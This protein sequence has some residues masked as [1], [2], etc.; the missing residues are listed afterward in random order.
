MKKYFF[1]IFSVLSLQIM[2]QSRNADKN[3]FELRMYEYRDDR[4]QAAI[5]EY[6][7]KALI[8]FLH[9]R[10]IGKIGAFTWMGN[11]TAKVKRLYVLIPTRTMAMIANFNKA[12]I[13]DPKVTASA[14]AYV[15]AT[16]EAPAYD[17]IVTYYIEGF[18]LA[19]NL[20]VPALKSSWEERVYELRSYEG[21]S[22]KKYLKKVEMFN[23][24]GE[25]DIFKRLNFN[26]VFYGEVLSG[27]TMP[28]L[29]YMTS[30]EN[31]KD[32]DAHWQAFR[33]D[34]AW[35]TLSA[36]K[37]YEKTVSKNVTLFLKARPYSEY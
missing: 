2:A 19:P 22:E 32:R 12:A 5:D 6:L 7:S 36:K 33:D 31:M 11:D 21:A 16:S 29:M 25:I 18:R 28:N 17:R 30:F 14:D 35:K 26:A 10:G 4:Q 27:P 13:S 23:E 37:E 1:F 3:Y 8:P 24:G 15:N 20:M 9:Q 34:A